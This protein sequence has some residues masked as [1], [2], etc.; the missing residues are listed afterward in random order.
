[1][2]N[3]RTERLPQNLSVVLQE[4]GENSVL[5]HLF[6]LTT[7]NDWTIFKNLSDKGC[8]LILQNFNN[9]NSSNK[10]RIEVKTRQKLYSTAK[11]NNFHMTAQFNL[12][13][14]EYDSCDFLVG[15]WFDLNAYFIVPKQ[16]L[17]KVGQKTIKYR[18]EAKRLKNGDFNDKTK[19]YLNKWN[20]I[21]NKMK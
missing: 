15:F 11:G 6:L 7:D 14:S 16:D 18:F 5:F 20:Q 4:I 21:S 3:K 10:L 17:K 8:D 1:M 12:T 2:K 19:S 13:E 9:S